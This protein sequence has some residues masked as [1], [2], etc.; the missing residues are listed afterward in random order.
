MKN[1]IFKLKLDPILDLRFIHDTLGT[2]TLEFE[3]WNGGIL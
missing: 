1:E 2:G 3:Y